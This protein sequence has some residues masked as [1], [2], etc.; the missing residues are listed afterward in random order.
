[1]KSLL[2]Y[3][4]FNRKKAGLSHKKA[5]YIIDVLFVLFASAMI[6]FTIYSIIFGI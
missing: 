4:R 2:K 3:R 6:Q 1:M 5:W